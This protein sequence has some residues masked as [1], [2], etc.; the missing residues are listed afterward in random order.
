MITHQNIG[1]KG[2]RCMVYLLAAATLQRPGDRFFQLSSSII[3]NPPATE[4]KNYKITNMRGNIQ[5]NIIINGVPRGKRVVIRC[6]EILQR[7]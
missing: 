7:L 2:F 3:S 4:S 1:F 6:Q 5:M